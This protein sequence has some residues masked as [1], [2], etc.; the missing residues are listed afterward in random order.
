MSAR[1]AAFA[2]VL[3]AVATPAFGAGRTVSIPSLTT[4]TSLDAGAAGMAWRSGSQ[5]ARVAWRSGSA[6][7][8]EAL[9]FDGA[10]KFTRLP[11]PWCADAVSFWLTRIGKRPLPNRMAVSALAYGPHV[12][13]PQPGDLA[14]LRGAREWAGHVGVVVAAHGD[15]IEII[16][17]NWSHRVARSIVSRRS[18]VAFVMT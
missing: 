18:V 6:L 12:A 9:R 1:A 3:L 14:V 13:D 8:A 16:S 11:G 15:A 2:V 4:A 17:G 10:G 5:G 7:V